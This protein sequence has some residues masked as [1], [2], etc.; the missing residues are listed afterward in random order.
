MSFREDG[1]ATVDWV[2]SYLERLSEFPVLAQ[3]APGEL[4]AGLPASPP[5]QGEAFADVLRE[6]GFNNVRSR[7]LTLGIVYLYTAVR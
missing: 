4:R 5:E 6:A 2:A 7:P 1:A 3:V